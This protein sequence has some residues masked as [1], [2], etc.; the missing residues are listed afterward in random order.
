MRGI[1]FSLSTPDLPAIEYIAVFSDGICQI[2]GGSIQSITKGPDAPFLERGYLDWRDAVTAL[3]DF[4]TNHGEFAKRR[5]VRAIK[6]SLGYGRGPQDD[7]SYAV[8][9]IEHEA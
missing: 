9:R 3:L 4:K 7:I 6:D 1:N 8:I 5:M 2:D